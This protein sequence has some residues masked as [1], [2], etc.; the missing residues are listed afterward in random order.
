MG[1]Y[2]L[3]LMYSIIMMLLTVAIIVAGV[4]CSFNMTAIFL[5]FMAGIH[6]LA[7]IIHFDLVTL[8]CGLGM[9]EKLPN[10]Q[11]LNSFFITKSLLAG[12][13]LVFYLLAN[14]YGYKYK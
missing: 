13:T 7:G 5:M 12:H 14:L 3:T 2:V 6:I 10:L 11:F 1:A 8:L 4:E 9:I